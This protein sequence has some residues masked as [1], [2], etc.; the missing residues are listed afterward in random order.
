MK[1]KRRCETCAFYDVIQPVEERVKPNGSVTETCGSGFCRISPPIPDR[2][3]SIYSTT[4]NSIWPIV[5]DLDW[6]GKWAE[7][8]GELQER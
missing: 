6:C 2:D 1:R 8:Y 7:A 5:Y 3:A 4:T